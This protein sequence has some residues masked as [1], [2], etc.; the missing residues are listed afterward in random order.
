MPPPFPQ[1]CS[2]LQEALVAADVLLRWCDQVEPRHAPA[3][4]ASNQATGNASGGLSSAGEIAALCD[5]FIRHVDSYLLWENLKSPPHQAGTLEGVLL[6]DFGAT[7]A[8]YEVRRTREGLWL[9]KNGPALADAL[10]R[11]AFDSSVVLRLALDVEDP[12]NGPSTVRTKWKDAKVTLQQVAL[13][14]RYGKPMTSNGPPAVTRVASEGNGG[15]DSSLPP[16]SES[17]PVLKQDDYQRILEILRSMSVHIERNPSTFAALD[18]EGIRNH[19]LLQLNGQFKGGATGETVNGAGKTDILIRVRDRNIFI[20]E[21]KFWYGQEKFGEAIDQ[22][23]SYLTWRDCKCALLIFNRN[24]D[25]TAVAQK[26][27]EIMQARTEH[28][29]TLAH[30]LLGDSQYIFVKADD[31]DREILITT[32]LFD[33]PRN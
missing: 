1:P 19:F 23:L 18:E 13:Q 21:C 25:T 15:T 28:R 24:K 10:V 22:L 5:D 31:P 3:T 20:A 30:D 26:I 11:H 2:D 8:D 12:D 17:E 4:P 14:L 7:S 32:Q 33:V 16:Y 9:R 29:Q 6:G 27:H